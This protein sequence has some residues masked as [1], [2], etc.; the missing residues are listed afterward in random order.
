MANLK[1]KIS[2]MKQEDD[3]KEKEANRIRKVKEARR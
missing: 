2:N 3:W 1:D